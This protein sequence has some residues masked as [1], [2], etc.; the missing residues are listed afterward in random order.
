MGIT[1]PSGFSL[2]IST[3]GLLWIIVA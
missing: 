1:I 3:F 2:L